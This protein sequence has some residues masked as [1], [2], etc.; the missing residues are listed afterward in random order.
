MVCNVMLLFVILYGKCPLDSLCLL[1]VL[2]ELTEKQLQALVSLKHFVTLVVLY[3]FT[4][5]LTHS[6]TCV[7]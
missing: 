1:S 6:Y 2:I 7:Y 5:A 3:K 4:L